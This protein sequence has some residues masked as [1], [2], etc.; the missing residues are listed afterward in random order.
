[1]YRRGNVI[2]SGV[3]GTVYEGLDLS[4]GRILA[5]KNIPVTSCDDVGVTVAQ[6]E[7]GTSRVAEEFEF[8][9]GEI[10][11]LRRMDHQ[12]L[13]KYYWAEKSDDG[14]SDYR[15]WRGFDDELGVDV[16][17]EFMAGG[18]LRTQ[19]AMFKRF[20]EGIASLNARQILEGLN[21]LHCQG[22]M[23]G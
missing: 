1:M 17:M 15:A 8:M 2:G 14:R 18:S 5:I 6:V 3:V 7:G 20:D 12:N 22:S 4:T 23:H 21:Y 13:I 10:D 11:Q 19:I 16:L 9:R